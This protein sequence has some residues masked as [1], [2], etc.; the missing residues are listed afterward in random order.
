MQPVIQSVPQTGLQPGMQVSLGDAV[1]VVTPDAAAKLRLIHD[2]KTGALIRC[3]CRMGALCG[4]AD[5]ARLAA[6]EGEGIRLLKV[7]RHTNKLKPG[8]LRG[9]RFRVLVRDLDPAG[10][11]D[12][13]HLPERPEGCCAQMAPRG[14]P[15]TWNSGLPDC[16]HSWQT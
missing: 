9:N 13:P 15:A 16:Q 2:N 5:E 14:Y 4:G 10:K 7:S 1:T 3:A 12:S 6:L 8:H 11:G